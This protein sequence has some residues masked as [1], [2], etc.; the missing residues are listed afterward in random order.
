MT[1]RTVKEILVPLSEYVVVSEDETIR[2]AMRKL[3]DSQYS[4]PP[5]KYY[6]R[7]TL[8]RNEKGDIVGKLGYHGFLAALDPPVREP[9]EDENACWIWNY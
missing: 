3:R 5:D 1:C 8:V 9:G 6:H 2:G 7:A 4:M